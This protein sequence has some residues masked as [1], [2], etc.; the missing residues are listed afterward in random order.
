MR[1][2][3]PI[4]IVAIAGFGA[5][6]ALGALAVTAGAAGSASVY[7]ACLS[8]GNLTKVGTTAPT[9][10]APAKQISWDQ[11]GPQGPA[12]NTILSGSGAP[13][14]NIGVTGNFY[15]E[16]SNHKLFGPATRTC[17]PRLCGTTWGAGISLVGPAGAAGQGPAYQ[18]TGSG[19]VTDDGYAPVAELTLPDGYFTLNATAGTESN[20]GANGMYCNLSVN[21]DNGLDGVIDSQI[22]RNPGELTL[23]GSVFYSPAHGTGYAIV[24]CGPFSSNDSGAQASVTAHLTATKVS[25]LDNQ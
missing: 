2:W 12:G 13:A 14:T 8:G 10:T 20:F 5:S 7:Y 6:T 22:N 16:T 9:C 15:L 1:V 17:T 3:K 21:Y 4:K 11:A 25:S 18:T 24:W 19:T 23:S